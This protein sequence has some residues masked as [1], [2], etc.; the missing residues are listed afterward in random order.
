[1][2]FLT[3]RFYID[4]R[5]GACGA[6]NV[7]DMWKTPFQELYQDTA[8]NKYRK[9]FYEKVTA[10]NKTFADTLLLSVDDILK[11]I[12]SQKRGKAA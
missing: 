6:E 3:L 12:I 2:L 10:Y 1:V 11:A 7:A 5:R 8:D 9:I 4:F